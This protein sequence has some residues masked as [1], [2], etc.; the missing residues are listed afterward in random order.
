LY[1]ISL[2]KGVNK[3]RKTDERGGIG[4]EFCFDSACVF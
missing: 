4:R 2:P 3:K 1:L